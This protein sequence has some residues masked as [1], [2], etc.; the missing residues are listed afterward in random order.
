VSRHRN[1]VAGLP[2]THKHFLKGVAPLTAYSAPETQ[3]GA[4]MLYQSERYENFSYATPVAEIYYSSIG[5]RVFDV[6]IEGGL[7]IDNLDLIAR[8]G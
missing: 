4:G 5:Q 1:L 8:V 6:E 2:A 7:V 3:R